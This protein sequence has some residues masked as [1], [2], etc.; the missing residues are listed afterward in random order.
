ML[1]TDVTQMA[2]YGSYKESPTTYVVENV[3]YYQY[4]EVHFHFECTVSD[5]LYVQLRKCG[6]DNPP[7]SLAPHNYFEKETRNHHAY[8]GL[9]PAVLRHLPGEDSPYFKVIDEGPDLKQFAVI[10]LHFDE[11]RNKLKIFG[12]NNGAIQVEGDNC[13]LTFTI[14]AMLMI[15]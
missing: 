15:G 9:D 8:Y 7:K 6:L 3:R 5:N 14:K 1:S 13:K 12:V 2:T 10:R 4:M 11:E